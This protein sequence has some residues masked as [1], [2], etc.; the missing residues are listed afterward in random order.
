M[1]T[2][3]IRSE[4][5]HQAEKARRAVAEATEALRIVATLDNAFEGSDD[6][7]LVDVS[8]IDDTHIA[9]QDLGGKVV[10]VEQALSRAMMDAALGEGRHPF[11]V[12]VFSTGGFSSVTVTHE[13]AQRALRR[14]VPTVFLHVGDFD[15]SGESIFES[16]SEDARRFVLMTTHSLDVRGNDQLARMMG[17]DPDETQQLGD[18]LRDRREIDLL[19]ERVALTA[20][21]VEE[22]DLE[23]APPKRS[24]SRSANWIGDTCQLE[25]MPPDVLAAT[26]RDAIEGH[27]DLERYEEE[28]ALEQA[29]EDL[30][31]QGL[32][33]ARAV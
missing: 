10:A 25:A 33:A 11:S 28:R 8:L 30:I 21:Q 12:P 1:R 14:D 22:H 6:L 19:P 24:D 32:E 2:H 23:T 15:P 7:P 3:T 16:M 17:L 26:V 9:A 27:L 18:L 4:Q 5:R 13:I 31:E 20:E 29:D